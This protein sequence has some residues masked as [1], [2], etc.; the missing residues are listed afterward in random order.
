MYGQIE[1]AKKKMPAAIE[2]YRQA[3][4][5][6]TR[7]ERTDSGDLVS[8]NFLVGF[9]K[10]L[11]AAYE[12]HSR[13]PEF[14]RGRKQNLLNA[15]ESYQKTFDLAKKLHDSGT[16]V[17]QSATALDEILA[18]IRMCDAALRKL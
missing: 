17:S 9:F 6:F 15:R 7:P 10:H 5:I 4:A 14:A 8:N 3:I 1:Q 11:A 2:K 18:K 16:T 12:E 13:D